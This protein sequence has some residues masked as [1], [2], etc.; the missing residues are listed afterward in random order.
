M[1]TFVMEWTA[2]GPVAVP[3]SLMTEE[4]Q[5]K[6]ELARREILIKRNILT[7]DAM[8]QIGQRII[9]QAVAKAKNPSKPKRTKNNELKAQIHKF[10][11]EN[12]N[13]SQAQQIKT[14]ADKF[15][16]STANMR[17]YVTRTNWRQ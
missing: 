6:S 1:E 5:A 4:R 3:E 17:Y 15:D 9:Q 11:R 12:K 10:L 14:G 7:D 16:I 2:K 13:L 8:A